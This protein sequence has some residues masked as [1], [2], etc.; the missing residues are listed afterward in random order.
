[1]SNPIPLAYT[2]GNHMHWVD[3]QWLA[4]CRATGVK[5]NINF[6]G[7]GYE[8][9][10][11]ES[12]EHLTKLREA[13][14]EGTIEVVGGSYGQPYGLFHGGE[15]NVRQRVY[16]VRTAMRV[17][18]C[19]PKTFWEEEFD[20]YPQLP[21]MLAG[22]G[23]TGASLYFQWTWHTPEVPMEDAPVVLWEGIDGTQIPT[24][25]RNRMNLHQWPEDFQILLDDLAANRLR[26]GCVVLSS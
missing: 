4:Y 25:T 1:M 21:Q 16:G 11:S 18:G 6:D 12:P 15:S 20:C 2:F 17:L 14:K 26:T 13:I 5:G 19:R 22:C 8:K 10:A 7:I 9:L 24:A 3:M 23:F